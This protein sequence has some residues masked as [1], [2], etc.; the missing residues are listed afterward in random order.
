M[1]LP[2]GTPILSIN[3]PT[4][5][6][7]FRAAA[8]ILP[9]EKIEIITPQFAR[10]VGVQVPVLQDFSRTDW[11][12]LDTRDEATL[13]ALGLGIWKRD[14]TQIHWLFPK[15]WYDSIPNGLEIDFIDGEKGAFTKG[16]TDGDYRF[17][18][19][20]FGF[21]QKVAAQMGRAK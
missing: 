21:V 4:F 6:E 17:G 7:D 16:E 8:G 2:K 3:S 14:E 12:D 10:T 19:L 13:K 5:V 1:K 11:D 15:E 20:A 9:G 18:C